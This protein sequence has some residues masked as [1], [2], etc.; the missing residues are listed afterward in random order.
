MSILLVSSYCVSLYLS[1]FNSL[2]LAWQ[3]TER[4]STRLVAR[5]TAQ[6]Q[7]TTGQHP[8]ALQ[9]YSGFILPPPG[10]PLSHPLPPITQP[11]NMQSPQ[12]TPAQPSQKRRATD[13][14]DSSAGPKTKKA[15]SKAKA[16]ADGSCVSTIK[17]TLLINILR[18]RI[19]AS[20]RGY[21]AKKRS[22]AAQIAAQNGTPAI[23]I[24]A[25]MLTKD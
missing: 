1:R 3:S 16:P 18:H 8:Y 6:E 17:W 20:K 19:A 22:E 2:D 5:G 21:N 9:V 11:S 23:A 12:P 14:E 4:A 7:A 24:R 10:Y 25:Y 15:K 13:G